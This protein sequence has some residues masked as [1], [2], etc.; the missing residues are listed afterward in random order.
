MKIRKNYATKIITFLTISITA[1]LSCVS[2]LPRLKS[3]KHQDTTTQ[4]EPLTEVKPQDVNW[5]A[6]NIYHEARG[7]SLPGMYAVGIVTMNRV[8]DEKYPKT[9]KGVITQKNQFSWV[10]DKHSDK[11]KEVQSYEI[12][13]N[14]A[15]N[16]LANNRKDATYVSVKRKLK[17]AT[18]YHAN[19][20]RPSWSRQKTLVTKIDHHLFYI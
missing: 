14:V 13:R 3:V 1:A 2:A 4:Q 11:A 5:L 20:I 12:A 15:K 16:I 7:E 19:Y 9:V 8:N 10:K 18:Y 6:L 17:G